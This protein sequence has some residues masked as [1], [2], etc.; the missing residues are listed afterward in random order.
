MSTF[1]PAEFIASEF[2][3]CNIDDLYDS[4]LHLNQLFWYASR[5]KPT[6]IMA[7]QLTLFGDSTVNIKSTRRAFGSFLLAEYICYHVHVLGVAVLGCG[8]FL[9]FII[10]R[11]LGI[12]RIF[13]CSFGNKRMRLHLWDTCENPAPCNTE[14]KAPEHCATSSASVFTEACSP[15][16]DIQVCDEFYSWLHLTRGANKLHQY[17]NFYRNS[18]EFKE[19]YTLIAY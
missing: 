1:H 19:H 5:H 12:K 11:I 9:P 13:P 16:S 4:T 17:S 2:Q 6:F 3:R 14:E 7:S 8:Q 15:L 18:F 10:K